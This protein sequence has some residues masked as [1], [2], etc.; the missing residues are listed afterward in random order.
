MFWGTLVYGN[1]QGEERNSSDKIEW[2]CWD[3]LLE[4]STQDIILH[5]R[6]LETSETALKYLNL[7]V[8]VSQ[9]TSDQY[10]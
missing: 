6:I 9:S 1:Q 7:I 8:N 3:G 5:N 4:R 2:K 10:T